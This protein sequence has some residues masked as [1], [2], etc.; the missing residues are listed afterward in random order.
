[1]EASFDGAFPFKGRVQPDE[2]LRRAIRPLWGS[3]DIEIG[4]IKFDEYFVITGPVRPMKYLLGSQKIRDLI[5]MQRNFKLSISHSSL[6]LSIGTL[7]PDMVLRQFELMI[8]LLMR[9]EM[10]DGDL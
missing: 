7:A 3:Q 5:L 10:M 8:E 6:L 2:P 9:I 1:M 4:D